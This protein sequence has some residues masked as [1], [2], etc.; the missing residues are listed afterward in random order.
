MEFKGLNIT[1]NV[2]KCNIRRMGTEY[3]SLSVWGYER[4]R[5]PSREDYFIGKWN[6]KETPLVFPGNG[7]PQP[8]T[9][10]CCD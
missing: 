4:G 7:S 1:V 6:I 10:K 8:K 2:N 5:V 3:P 9:V